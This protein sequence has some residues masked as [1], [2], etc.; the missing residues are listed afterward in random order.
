VPFQLQA[1][2]FVDDRQKPHFAPHGEVLAVVVAKLEAC[3]LA[4]AQAETE[5]QEQGHP[6]T[7]SLGDLPWTQIGYADRA[8]ELSLA[9]GLGS[10]QLLRDRDFLSVF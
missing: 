9:T 6:L 7:S 1:Q 3:Q 4:L 8:Q 2:V 10:V 5:K